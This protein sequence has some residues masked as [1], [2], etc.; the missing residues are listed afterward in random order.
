MPYLAILNLFI[1]NLTIVTRY[2][3]IF[4]MV[5]ENADFK[6]L[7]ENISGNLSDSPL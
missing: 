6:I 7:Q 4:M 2:Q 3:Q 1:M 5:K